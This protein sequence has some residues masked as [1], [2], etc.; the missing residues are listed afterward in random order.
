M[1][2]TKKPKNE[3]Y[4]RCTNL[5]EKYRIPWENLLSEVEGGK[6]L[7]KG[8]ANTR[9][10]AKSVLKIPTPKSSMVLK[11]SKMGAQDYRAKW[12][13]YGSYEV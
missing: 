2:Q 5:Y 9:V 13:F 11:I 3:K 12:I 10:G 8:K 1:N 4:K 6:D 7:G